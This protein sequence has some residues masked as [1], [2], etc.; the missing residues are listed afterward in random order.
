MSD[1]LSSARASGSRDPRC[2]LPATWD[3]PLGRDGEDAL[4]RLSVTTRSA[5][6]LVRRVLAGKVLGRVS[7]GAVSLFDS[8]RLA[9]DAMPRSS[10]FVTNFM[11]CSG[12]CLARRSM[13]RTVRCS[14]A[15]CECQLPR[16]WPLTYGFSA[17]ESAG[18]PLALPPAYSVCGP[19]RSFGTFQGSSCQ[20]LW[21]RGLL[22]ARSG[23][24]RTPVPIVSVHR[25]RSFRTPVGMGP[26]GA[27]VR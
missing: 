3:G 15:R 24:F 13:T 9:T 20:V 6:G 26:C 16:S 7:V 11:C 4:D 22:R 12:R 17:Q 8:S 1:V 2:P 27:G 19:R 18:V 10:R 5:S 23:G 25:F 21:L 14:G